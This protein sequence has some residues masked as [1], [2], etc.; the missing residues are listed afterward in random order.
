[1]D[2]SADGLS[3]IFVSDRAI[4]VS[5]A[6]SDRGMHVRWI[7]QPKRSGKASSINEAIRQVN[8]PLVI[9]HDA[10]TRLHPGSIA[11][12]CE[13]FVDQKVGGVAGEK[14]VEILPGFAPA[15]EGYYWRYE[16]ARKQQDARFYSVVGGAGELFAM[17]TALFEPLP[18]D[19]LLDDMEL[20]W[21]VIRK[22]YRISYAP[23]AITTELPS[24]S[25][26]EESR[27]KIRIAAGAYQFLD[28][29]PLRE[30]FSVSFRYGLQFLYRKWVRWVVW[31]VFTCGIPIVLV[32]AQAC[33]P[34]HWFS[35]FLSYFVG[36]AALLFLVGGILSGLRVR[37]GWFG[38][39][40]YFL[41]VQ[42][43]QLRGWF[44]YRFGTSSA[45]WEK[46]DR[47]RDL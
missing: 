44:T 29:H 25:L 13:P 45:I 3:I 22:G 9:F 42:Y 23:K 30:V 35:Q 12:L 31:P 14:R 33:F 6:F 36:V 46:S 43:C 17:R 39:P 21:Q 38:L 32:V 41:F 37:V 28:R 10:N 20:S 18:S 16:S 34:S 11:A 26:L 24:S 27:R 1:M 47:S 8:T 4:P 19:C 7:L 2:A 15:L 40:F 5:Q